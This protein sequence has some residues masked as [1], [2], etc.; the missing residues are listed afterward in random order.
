MS[1]VDS[2]TAKQMCESAKQALA[3]GEVDQAIGRINQALIFHPHSADAK[4]LLGIAYAQKGMM[5]EALDAME[6]AVSVSE[7][8]AV[9]HFN[10]GSLLQ[11]VG[12]I[13]EAITQYEEALRINPTYEKAKLALEAAKKQW[14]M[15]PH[16]PAHAKKEEPSGSRWGAWL[17]RGKR[18]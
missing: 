1:V 12:R 13:A 2:E 16:P 5:D 4:M 14:A 8:N 3:R 9:V 17:G 6:D 11:R 7:R 18:K 15:H 10:Y